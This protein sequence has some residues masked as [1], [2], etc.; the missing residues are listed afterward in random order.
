MAVLSKEDLIKKITA[1]IGDTPTDEGVALLEDVTDTVNAN[2][3]DGVDWK[4]KY[5]ENDK[6]W[7]KKYID[8]FNGKGDDDDPPPAGNEGAEV[9]TSYESLF[10]NKKE[11]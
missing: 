5:E 3:S 7:R 11:N 10:E 9:K 4:Q 6:T 8:R 2:G 1:F